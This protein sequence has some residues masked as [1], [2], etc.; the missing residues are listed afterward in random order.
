ML[1]NNQWKKLVIKSKRKF[2]KYLE[3]NDNEDT[4]IQNLWDAA[5]A[6]LRGKF[7]AIQTYFRKQEKISN[8]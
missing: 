5:K 6:I 7:M 3:R 2:K 8:K 4:M 1:P